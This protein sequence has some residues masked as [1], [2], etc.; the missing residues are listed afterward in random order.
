ME[1]PANAA[2]EEKDLIST[3]INLSSESDVQTAGSFVKMQLADNCPTVLI[4]LVRLF[5]YLVPACVDSLLDQRGHYLLHMC[6]V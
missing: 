3:M 4:D 1:N 2:F 6:I 5:H